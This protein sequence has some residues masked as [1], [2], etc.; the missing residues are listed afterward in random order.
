M[1]VETH[2]ENFLLGVQIQVAKGNLPPDRVR[3]YWVE[4]DE[5]GASG[6]YPIDLDREGYARGFPNDVFDKYVERSRILFDAREGPAIK[7]LS[8]A[9]EDPAT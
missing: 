3:I 6:L 4:Q 9:R 8:E 7:G 5:D 1:L 2:S